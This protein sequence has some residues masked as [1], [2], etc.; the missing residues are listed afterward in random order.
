M[1]ISLNWIKKYTDIKITNEELIS[2]LHSQLGEVEQVIDFSEK[3]KD[4]LLAEIIERKDHP[5]ADKLAIYQISIGVKD[6]I[7]VVAGDKDLKPGDHVA[8]FKP[9]A[10]VPFNPHP[11]KYDGIIRAVKLRGVESNGML[12]SGRE[13]DINNNHERVMIIETD[14]EPGTPIAD[15]LG[16]DDTVLEIENKA[17]TNRADCFSTIGIA[18]E[19]AGIQRLKFTS[20]EWFSN[21]YHEL[22]ST[23]KSNLPLEIKNEAFNLCP[24]YSA[25]TISN[26]AVKDSPLWL[27]TLL[28]R[29][30][31]RPINNIVDITNY[32]MLL[33]GQPLHAF[34]Y[35]KLRNKDKNG[36]NSAYIT[37]R[38]AKNGE[39]LNALNQNV[40]TL[41]DTNLVIC[42]STNPVALAGMIGGADTEID[43]TTKNVVL[44][45]ANF[46][47]YNN[48]KSS[49]TL[50]IFTDAVTRYSKGQDPANTVPAMKEAQKMISQLSGGEVENEYDLRDQEFGKTHLVTV[51]L[52]KLNEHL[53]TNFTSKEV[54]SILQNVELKTSTKNDN[55]TVEVPSFRNDIKLDVDVH[56]EV[57]RL[58]GYD[59]IKITLPQ[60][61]LLP[62]AHNKILDLK[63]KIKQLMSKYNVNEVYSYNFISKNLIESCGLDLENAYR[64]RN[65]LSPE[66]E[67]MRPSLVPSLCEI[68]RKNLNSRRDTIIIYE[69][70]RSHRKSEIDKENLPIELDELTLLLS[71]KDLSN[72][73][74]Y[75]GSVYYS[76]KE[77][78]QHLLNDLNIVNYEYVSPDKINKEQLPDWIERSLNMYDTNAV[79]LI[80]LRTEL[81]TGYIGIV[82]ELSPSLKTKIDLPNYT[83]AMQ[84]NINELLSSISEHSTYREP[85]RYPSLTND[86][87]FELNKDIPYIHLYDLLDRSL[88]RTNLV[89][90][91]SPVDIYSSD[92]LST[93]DN[94]RI[95]LRIELSSEDKTLENSE[96]EKILGK[97]IKFIKQEIKAEVI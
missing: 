44:E 17:L 86:L 32:I 88:K 59:N 55:I 24:R 22:R 90:T 18:R 60:K 78:V 80:R 50:G 15:V 57:G 31:M 28:V 2:K 82:G 72:K 95:T 70:N 3:Y 38:L 64:L 5:E 75:K 1:K 68:T 10:K 12:A 45:S 37:V 33:T 56:E 49:M 74:I 46:D 89:Y 40:Y 87:C 6:T 66:L 97:S 14:K 11:E 94:R 73:K 39:K 96:I 4:V 63:W 43:E 8:Y 35:D 7:Q 29:S 93:K 47:M 16:M 19:I 34:D 9:G 53:G 81:N 67:Y 27:Q 85:S 54:S 92:K 91:I 13:L 42:D 69:I 71:V 79:A 41:F 76:V 20:P 25:A 65:S 26:V 51:G 30:G 36:K 62:A 48:R 61:S 58:N 23:A 52:K 21:K 83:G 77:Y 84:F